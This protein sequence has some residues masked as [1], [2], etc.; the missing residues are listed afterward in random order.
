M[1][2]PSTLAEQSQT[3]ADA[4]RNGIVQRCDIVEYPTD[5]G[6]H[7]EVQ[8]AYGSQVVVVSEQS[9]QSYDL[10]GDLPFRFVA[11][12]EQ[13][14]GQINPNSV[15]HVRNHP[16]DG[17]AELWDVASKGSP[18]FQLH[19][20]VPRTPD[21]H[22]KLGIIQGTGD[23]HDRT[24]RPLTPIELGPVERLQGRSL[25]EQL[26]SEILSAVKTALIWSRYH[27]AQAQGTGPDREAQNEAQRKLRGRS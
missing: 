13:Q 7:Y 3:L 2:N 23:R 25:E 9:Q 20:R 5:S 26:T 21:E 8:G 11:S 6:L 27:V 14:L 16:Q 17:D 1:P 10:A 19:V 24:L 4:V 12:R 22:I 15:G 18:S